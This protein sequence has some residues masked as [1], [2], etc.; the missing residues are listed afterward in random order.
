MTSKNVMV[1]MVNQ[2]I[3]GYG[4][5]SVVSMVGPYLKIN[6]ASEFDIGKT[7]LMVGVFSILGNILTAKVCRY[8]YAFK[9]S[10][11]DFI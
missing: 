11:L 10:K 5:A 4:S 2:F 3:L 9:L 1:P 8:S 6:G 7:F